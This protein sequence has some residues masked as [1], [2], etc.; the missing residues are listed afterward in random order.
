M[1]RAEVGLLEWVMLRRPS[2]MICY[3]EIRLPMHIAFLSRH[4]V[5]I[6]MYCRLEASRRPPPPVGAR[7]LPNKYT[8]P[9]AYPRRE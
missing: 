3:H 5:V 4:G 2:D 1:A 6:H 9:S 8:G 7:Y